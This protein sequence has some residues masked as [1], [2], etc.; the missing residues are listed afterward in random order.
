MKFLTIFSGK[1]TYLVGLAM[2]VVAWYQQDH[3][4]AMEGLAFIFI[5]LGIAKND[6]ST[7]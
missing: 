6:I 7:K 1:K 4:M 2:L 5:R 3:Q